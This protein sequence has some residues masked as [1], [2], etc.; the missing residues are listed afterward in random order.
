MFDIFFSPHFSKI[1]PKVAKKTTYLELILRLLT[2]ICDL[3]DCGSSQT[4]CYTLYH[5][6]QNCIAFGINL[7][8]GEPIKLIEFN[9]K[10]IDLFL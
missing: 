2:T 4:F 8:N 5:G 3:P 9:P 6:F 1:Y 7:V 10:Y